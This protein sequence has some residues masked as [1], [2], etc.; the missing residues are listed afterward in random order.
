V[1]GENYNHFEFIET[2]ANPYGTLGRAALAQMKLVSDQAAFSCTID[3][4]YSA[5]ALLAGT[6]LGP[7][8]ILAPIG[9]GGMG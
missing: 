8:E 1:S 6:R 4:H 5:M 3:W 7:Y 9:E 2:L